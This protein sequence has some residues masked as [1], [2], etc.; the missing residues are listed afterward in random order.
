MKA[1][2]EISNHGL[3]SLAKQ[4]LPTMYLSCI[5][6]V[7]QA[8]RAAWNVHDTTDNDKI[9]LMAISL[10]M[11]GGLDKFSLFQGGPLM[12]HMERLDNE[13]TE[14]INSAR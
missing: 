5:E 4:T 2:N 13:V 8:L 7:N 12:I 3:W 10:I 11:R 14:L 6:T 1:I 9:K